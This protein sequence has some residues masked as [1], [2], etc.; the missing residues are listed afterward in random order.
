MQNKEQMNMIYP[1]RSIWSEYTEFF[2]RLVVFSAIFSLPMMFLVNYAFSGIGFT[3][4]YSQTMALGLSLGL[5]RLFLLSIFGNNEVM[6]TNI[7]R[8]IMTVLIMI[9]EG[10]SLNL[11][12]FSQNN[13]EI[14]PN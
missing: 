13:Q 7:L 11:V 4:N 12:P 10:R 1:P 2:F 3:I 8:G 6:N 5:V 9:M 14:T